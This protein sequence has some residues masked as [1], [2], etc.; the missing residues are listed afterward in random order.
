MAICIKG[1]YSTSDEK[2][3]RQRA[4][5]AIKQDWKDYNSDIARGVV[6]KKHSQIEAIRKLRG[7]GLYDRIQR[8]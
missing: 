8:G 6:H 2:D 5:D 4:A 7:E 3:K 1:H